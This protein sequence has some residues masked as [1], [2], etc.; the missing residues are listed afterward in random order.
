MKDQKLIL[1]NVS[2]NFQILIERKKVVFYFLTKTSVWPTN[3]THA[4]DDTKYINL[5]LLQF[6]YNLLHKNVITL[7]Q[8]CFDYLVY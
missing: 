4:S 3:F 5:K 6:L 1:Q 8:V 7:K 2:E